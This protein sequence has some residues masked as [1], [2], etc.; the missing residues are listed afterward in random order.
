MRSGRGGESAFSGELRFQANGI[1]QG[2]MVTVELSP[3]QVKTD[4]AAAPAAVLP[5]AAAQ[6]VPITPRAGMSAKA[7]SKA[8][9]MAPAVLAA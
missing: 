8:P 7:G 3:Q 9:A 6:A 1:Q 4:E 5:P 2:Q